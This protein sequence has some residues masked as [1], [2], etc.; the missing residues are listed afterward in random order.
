[1]VSIGKWNRNS[2]HWG[3]GLALTQS[4][5]TLGPTLSRH[6]T[7]PEVPFRPICPDS[8]QTFLVWE[9]HFCPDCWETLIGIIQGPVLV[10]RDGHCNRI[11]LQPYTLWSMYG[12]S[13]SPYKPI[14]CRPASP[15][16]TVMVIHMA[17]IQF[18]M[19][20]GS[21]ELSYNLLQMY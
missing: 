21:Y 7:Y 17:I 1:M 14:S 18:I 20:M 11:W 2:T 8:R 13:P 16:G 6:L 15:A 9:P 10:G 5:P 3:V 12:H 4:A 19:G